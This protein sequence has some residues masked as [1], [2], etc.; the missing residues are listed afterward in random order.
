MNVLD[1]DLLLALAAMPIQLWRR[2]RGE[3]NILN[4]PAAKAADHLSKLVDEI[5]S[6][7]VIELTD[8]AKMLQDKWTS[9]PGCK[10][11]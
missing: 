7:T 9:N 3:P 11:P 10:G 8:L 1:R 6:L 4:A 2:A 5:S